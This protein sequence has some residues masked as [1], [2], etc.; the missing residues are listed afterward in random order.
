MGRAAGQAEGQ[1]RDWQKERKAAT[2][3]KEALVP[4]ENEG[5]PR[6]QG[7]IGQFQRVRNSRFILNKE[8]FETGD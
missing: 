4:T 8:G 5:G 2:G 3:L 6:G 1:A 7:H